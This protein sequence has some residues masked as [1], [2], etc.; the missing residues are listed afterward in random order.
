MNKEKIKQNAERAY[1]YLQGLGCD[2][3]DINKIASELIILNS[4]K[5]PFEKCL[6][7]GGELNI[8]E[9]E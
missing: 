7:E 2:K 4:N 6:E 8:G 9:I 5:L 3:K 1:N